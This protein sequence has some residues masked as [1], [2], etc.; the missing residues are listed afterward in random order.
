MN[1][2]PNSSYL[3][4]LKI[5]CTISSIASD[6]NAVP[7]IMLK[8]KGR[9]TIANVLLYSLLGY[10]GP[11]YVSINKLCLKSLSSNISNLRPFFTFNYNLSLF[12]STISHTFE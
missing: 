3:L 8:F 4:V 12:N 11:T 9:R 5:S 7:M 2:A 1:L 6:L 10:F